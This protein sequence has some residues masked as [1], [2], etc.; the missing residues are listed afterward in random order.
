MTLRDHLRFDDADLCW[1]V[2]YLAV[3]LQKGNSDQV[4]NPL[5]TWSNVDNDVRYVPL[6]LICEEG[7]WVIVVIS[8]LYRLNGVILHSIK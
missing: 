1:R 4:L 2:R 7:E 5:A 6:H 3:R 8:N